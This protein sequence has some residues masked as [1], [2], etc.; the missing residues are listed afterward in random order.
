V[1]CLLIKVQ[2]ILTGDIGKNLLALGKTD[3]GIRTPRSCS[4][5]QQ[6]ATLI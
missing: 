3:L 5:Q 4:R 6:A 1:A 2:V